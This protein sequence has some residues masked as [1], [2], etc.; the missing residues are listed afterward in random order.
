[1]KLHLPM[2]L[3]AALLACLSTPHAAT[4][5]ELTWTG[6]EGNNVWT[7]NGTPDSSP[8]NGNA[9]YTD[10]DTVIFGTLEGQTLVE[11]LISSTVTPAGLTF[12]S[13]TTSYTLKGTGAMA[14]GG[15]LSKSGTST[16]RLETSN[17]NFSGTINLD[18]GVLE[19][20]ADGVLG[21]GKIV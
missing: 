18:G 14:G 3:L 5:A 11:A 13:D 20:G 12:N 6:A 17:T 4:A 15:T 9:V 8:W 16:L 1:M 7:L 21:T 10:E 2:T 19:L